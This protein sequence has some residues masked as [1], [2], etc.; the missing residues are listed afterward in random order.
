MWLTVGLFFLGYY[1]I[2][3]LSFLKQTTDPSVPILKERLGSTLWKAGTASKQGQ[4]HIYCY[5]PGGSVGDAG[6]GEFII[7]RAQ[8]IEDCKGWYGIINVLE[9][10]EFSETDMLNWPS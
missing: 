2:F 6:N 9:P 1:Y 7:K 8:N 5:Y 10:P 3:Y 4:F